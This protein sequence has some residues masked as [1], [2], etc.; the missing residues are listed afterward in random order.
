MS[1][2]SSQGCLL[3]M[4]SSQC[5]LDLLGRGHVYTDVDMVYTRHDNADC[6]MRL[7]K[8]GLLSAVMHML[9]VHAP[10]GCLLTITSY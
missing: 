8:L 1:S 6:Y 4:T 2:G 5:A 3:N 10:C 9:L 7:K